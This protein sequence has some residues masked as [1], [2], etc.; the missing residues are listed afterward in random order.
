M[1][2][3]NWQKSSLCGTGDSCIHVAATPRAIHITESGDPAGAVLITTP[4][5]FR[6]L[7]RALREDP[8][9]G[10]H[11]TLGGDATVRL[12]APDGTTTVTTDR[13]RWDAFVR[14]VRAG[15]F[16]HFV[17]QNPAHSHPNTCQKPR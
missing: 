6:G 9:P 8:H 14:G 16:D 15:E 13:S 7:L 17:T 2:E 5:A 3:L 11:V 4:D 1:T 10:D 12:H